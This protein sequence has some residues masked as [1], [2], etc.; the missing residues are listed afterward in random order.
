[1]STYNKSNYKP[2]SHQPSSP[3]SNRLNP[4]TFIDDNRTLLARKR[5]WEDLSCMVG[6]EMI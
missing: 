2:H 6:S 5:G 1:M 4:I 3:I